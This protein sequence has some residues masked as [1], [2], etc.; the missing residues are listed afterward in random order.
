ME[1]IIKIWKFVVANADTLVAIL[2]SILATTFG[3]V[4][5]NQVLLLVG[6]ASTLAILALSLIRDRQNRETLSAQ[7]EEL[8]K[9]LPDQLSATAF[10]RK[11][12]PVDAKAE[13]ES[14]RELWLI[15]YRLSRTIPTYITVFDKKLARGDK[16]KVM[17]VDPES[18][19]AHYCN[20]TMSY[21]MEL[22]QFRESIRTNINLLKNLENNKTSNLEIRLIDHPLPFGGYGFNINDSGGKLYIKQY[23]YQ[24]KIDGIRFVLTSRDDIWYDVYRKQLFALWNSAMPVRKTVGR[25]HVS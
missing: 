2:V 18:Q 11:D 5:E 19:A 8:R 20:Q 3:A 14:A 22:E 1:K 23:E 13:I 17:L 4:Q 7:I 15:G 10:F 25:H 16:I 21:P 12:F 6:I 9:H 24:A